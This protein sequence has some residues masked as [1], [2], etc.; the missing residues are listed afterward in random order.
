MNTSATMP[1]VN[2]N[3]S[4]DTKIQMLV[5]TIQ[6]EKF[7]IPLTEIQEIMTVLPLTP[8][9]HA[10]PAIR[11]IINVRS[12]VA[13]AIDIATVLGIRKDTQAPQYMIL[14]EFEKSFYALLVD[15]VVGV[16]RTTADNLR[17]APELFA[18]K[19]AATYVSGALIIPKGKTVENKDETAI[20][21][22]VGLDD[23]DMTLVLNLSKIFSDATT[24]A[25]Q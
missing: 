10:P 23:T 18:S 11:G 9:P 2:A 20:D 15:T 19:S 3:V 22:A 5:C 16:L 21:I 7:A 13:T 14:A 8:V 25:T 12:K 4:Q 17:D 1:A 24:S 6:N